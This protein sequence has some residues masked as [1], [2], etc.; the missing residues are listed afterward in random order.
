MPRYL[1]E[2]HNRLIRVDTPDPLSSPSNSQ[3]GLQL[4]I[5]LESFNMAQTRQ[6]SGTPVY[7]S[8]FHPIDDL[9][10]QNLPREE[11]PLVVD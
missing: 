4:F 6:G 11:F 9:I 3:S 7:A 5:E 8:D 1:R 2:S 10:R